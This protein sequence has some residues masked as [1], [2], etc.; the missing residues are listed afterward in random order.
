MS[1]EGKRIAIMIDSLR[2]GGAQRSMLDLAGGFRDE[3][4]QVDLVVACP[5]NS[6][7]LSIP[8]GVHRIDLGASRVLLSIPGLIKYLRLHRP[9]VLITAL[10]HVNLAALFSRCFARVP[11]QVIVSTHTMLS[12]SSRY[13]RRS[14][15]ALFAR[16]AHFF[17]PWADHVIAVS[18]AVADDLA[19]IADLPRPIIHVIYN[20]IVTPGLT[21]LA[22][23]D[24]DHP[25][26]LPDEPP[27][28]LG[29][30]RLATVK[31]FPTLIRAFN[32]VRL[33]T[34]ARLVILGEGEKR[35][36]MM[37][38]IKSL[39]LEDEVSLPGFV[40]N[41]FAFMARAKVF[42]LSSAWEG[43]GRV[44]VEAM[45]CGT[46]VV[47]TNCPGGVAEI[48]Q[49]GRYGPAVPVGDDEALAQ[50]ILDT[51]TSPVSS[52][53]LRRRAEDFTIEEIINRYIDLIN[54]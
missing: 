29:V 47:S 24:L 12:L 20:P 37:Q 33:A 32:Q 48:L 27:V 1:L 34:P 28:I 3:G 53:I 54:G 11:T 39:S 21:A 14:R 19:Q 42:V 16:L 6:S 38:L 36:E 23:A 26:F 18:E 13:D 22:S 50:A 35:A 25:W 44:L 51:M 41:P 10:D 15:H 52:D 9:S 49:N 45:A 2:V 30:G 17:Y 40:H 5:S 46:P 8:S 43:F 4:F 31:D 7:Y